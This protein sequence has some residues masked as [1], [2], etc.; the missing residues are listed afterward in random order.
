[1]KIGIAYSLKPSHAPTDGPDDA[2]EEFDSP[3]T[4]KAIA[5]VLR[6]LGHEVTEL[7]DGKEL[8]QKLLA[9]PPELVFNLAEGYGSSRNREARVPAVCEMLGIP[10]T[11]SDP[12][13]LALA[14]DKDACRR[15]VQDADVIVPGGILVQFPDGEYDGDF[16]EFPAMAAESDLHLPLIAKPVCEGSSKGIRSRCLIEEPEQIGPVVLSLWRDYRQ[17]VLVEEFIAGDEVTVGVVGNGD[18]ARILGVMRII[19]KEASNRFVYSLEVKRDWQNQ[20][21]YEVPP[22]LPPETI[23]AIEDT[24]WPRMTSSAAGI[25]PGSIF[26]SAMVSLTFWKPTP[27]RA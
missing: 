8:L 11:G 10:Y 7:G 13:T 27:C 5:E 21:G 25:G 24:A 26:V 16:V 15:M 2:F 6:G 4:I 9:A 20:V 1:M 19:P 12:L 14:L 3:I 18:E 23:R 22:A 17:P